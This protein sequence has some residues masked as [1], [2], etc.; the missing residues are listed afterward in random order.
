VSIRT[1]QD[2]TQ[3]I[4]GLKCEHNDIINKLRNSLSSSIR[5]E[6]GLLEFKK[7]EFLL[8]T[9]LENESFL[10]YRALMVPPKKKSVVRSTENSSAEIIRSFNSSLKDIMEDFF[11]FS[12]T[13]KKDIRSADHETELLRIIHMIENRFEL[14]ETVV[15]LMYERQQPNEPICKSK[16]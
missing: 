16:H 7:A 6:Q 2:R 10:V 4:E 1:G 13:L 11:N 9:H 14:E 3:I 15:F 8:R 12:K 5:S